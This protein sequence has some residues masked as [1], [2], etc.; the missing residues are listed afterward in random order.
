MQVDYIRDL[1]MQVHTF[2]KH[3]A[4]PAGFGIGG[5]G[6]LTANNFRIMRLGHIKFFL[7]EAR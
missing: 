5:W 6:N 3:V 7:A 1:T 2:L 4:E